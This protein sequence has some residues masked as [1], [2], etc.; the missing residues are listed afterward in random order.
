M[1]G[2]SETLRETSAVSSA[3]AARGRELAGGWS[4][5]ANSRRAGPR[6]RDARASGES[7]TDRTDTLKRTPPPTVILPTLYGG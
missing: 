2:V 1:V 7:H 3:T 5:S 6:S 4:R